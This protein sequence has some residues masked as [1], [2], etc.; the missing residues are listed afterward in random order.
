MKRDYIL[1]QYGNACEDFYAIY[2][3]D[4]KEMLNSHPVVHGLHKAIEA[5][6]AAI[7]TGKYRLGDVLTLTELIETYIER[8]RPSATQPTDKRYFRFQFRISEKTLDR[9][10]EEP[11]KWAFNYYRK[12][13]GKWETLQADF[14]PS[15]EEAEAYFRNAYPRLFL[16]EE[17]RVIEAE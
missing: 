7:L 6:D 10:A 9:A 4:D 15:K 17:T 13:M 5:M 16:E 8:N 2:D 14:F 1:L 11:Y 12:R 3:M